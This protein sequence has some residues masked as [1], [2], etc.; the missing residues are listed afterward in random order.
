MR[1]YVKGLW[2]VYVETNTVLGITLTLE[3]WRRDIESF[4]EV[5]AQLEQDVRDKGANWSGSL[6]IGPMKRWWLFG[7]KSGDST[8][9]VLLELLF[10]GTSQASGAFLTAWKE[11]FREESPRS[12]GYNSKTE[13]KR[14]LR[15]Q[16]VGEAI[17]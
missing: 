13:S 14:R 1:D 11:N 7:D 2:G 8:I 9:Q 10:H 17:A 5:V 12:D 3:I 15:V 6:T 16:T 4:D